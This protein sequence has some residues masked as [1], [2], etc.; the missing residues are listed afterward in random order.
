MAIGEIQSQKLLGENNILEIK[1]K[2][3]CSNIN[4]FRKAA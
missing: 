1:Q 3:Q 2:I 4:L